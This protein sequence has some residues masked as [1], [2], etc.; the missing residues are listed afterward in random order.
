MTPSPDCHSAGTCAL[1]AKYSTSGSLYGDITGRIGYAADQ[2]LFYGKGGVAFVDTD[3]KANYIGQNCSM[4]HSC[5]RN[6]NPPVKPS[7]FD[8]EQSDMLWG[9]TVGG[10]IEYA[11]SPAWSVKIE[12]LH[13]DFGST[14][15]R[16]DGTYNIVGTPWHST[17][18]GDVNMSPTVDSVKLGVNYRLDMA[19]PLK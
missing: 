7:T 4:A 17:L 11:L 14:S 6:Y 1:D 3:I 5:G 2:V 12:Y 15:F 18:K 8:F 13:F 16:H 10:G 19:S 9:W